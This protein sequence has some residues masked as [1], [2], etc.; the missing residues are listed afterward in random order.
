MRAVLDDY[1]PTYKDQVDS[2]GQQLRRGERGTV[3]EVVP[4]KHHN[5][6]RSASNERSPL[7]DTDQLCGCPRALPDGRYELRIGLSGVSR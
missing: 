1:F 6:S 7:G 3:G 2:V 4:R 5:V